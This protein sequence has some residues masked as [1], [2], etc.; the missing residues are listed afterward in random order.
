MSNHGGTCKN[1]GHAVGSHYD[2]NM[3]MPCRY[4]QCSRC[5]CDYADIHRRA[6]AKAG[7][8]DCELPRSFY[9]YR[10]SG[11]GIFER[12]NDPNSGAAR[13]PIAGGPLE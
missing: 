11:V 4:C 12:P 3:D 10:R 5:D 13:G 8:D 2:N 7:L 1:C 9:S 6:R